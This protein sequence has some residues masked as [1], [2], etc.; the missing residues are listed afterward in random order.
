MKTD[1]A[2][3][4]GIHAGHL[5]TADSLFIS[6]GFVA[7]GWPEMG[8]LSKL[9]PTREAFKER[10]IEAYPGAKPGAIPNNA[11]QLFRFVHEMKDGDL[12]V[13]PAKFERVVHIGRVSGSYRCDP[14]SE[15]SHPNLR[16]VKWLRAVPRTSFTQGALYELGS[17]MSFFQISNYADEFRRA[18]RGEIAPAESRSDDSVSK[19]AADIEQTTKDFILK[20]LDQDFK[21]HPFAQFFGDLLNAMG[22]RTRVSPPGTDQGI[23]II[24]H[25]DEL[26]LEPPRV[27]V[28]AKS[29]GGAVG[30]PVVSQ[31]YG[32][33]G[34]GEYGLVVTTSSFTPQAKNFATQKTNLRLIDG[35]ELV[36][37]I[38]E[39]YH[40]LDVRYKGLLP[41]RRVYV[42]EAREEPD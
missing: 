14:K 34:D 25:R 1:A 3:V 27:K 13:Y 36:D 40:K 19:V 42:P 5:P 24:A 4:W 32:K 9:Q 22:W 28:Q 35:D 8:D 10:V 18:A 23:D 11:G 31:L 6:A 12:I 38:F 29:G 41:L 39:H 37:L 15:P 2:T 26:G 7:L 16:P 33:V 21:G 20:T 17:A 30:D